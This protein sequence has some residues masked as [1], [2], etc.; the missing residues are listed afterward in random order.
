M[1]GKS[2]SSAPE[3]G[4]RQIK[5]TRQ[6]ENTLQVDNARQVKKNRENR[7]KYTSPVQLSG[8]LESIAE[9]AGRGNTVCDVGCDHAHI[10][11]RLL[12]T[13]AFAR[14]IGMDVLD[15]PLGKAAGNLDLYGMADR[16]DLRLSDGLDAYE[17][18]EADTVVITGM[19]GTLMREILLREPEK[20]RSIPALV[21]GP[22]SDPDKVRDAL[23]GLGFVIE[24]ERLIFED[25]KYYPVLR[26][27]SGGESAACRPKDPGGAGEDPASGDLF[28]AEIPDQIRREAEDLF[29][30]VLLSR[31]DPLLKEFLTR[32]IAVLE[33]IRGSVSEAAESLGQEL[34]AAA[35]PAEAGKDPAPEEVLAKA[36]QDLR[37]EAA[38]PAE[39]GKDPAPETA[40][41]AA[42]R[43]PSGALREKHLQ[44]LREIDHSLVLYRAALAVYREE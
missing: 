29:G 9:L 26:A 41:T 42:D 28:P 11:I 36:G 22:Q 39:A 27:V 4:A 2:G 14:A 37:P 24:D 21:L 32:R 3:G 31:R 43:R 16:V 18:G 5:N 35:A 10:P 15:G 12:Q 34:S 23:R 38:A 44:K 30:P 33:R 6:V 40:V 8:R 25:G 20:T 19:G 17:A 1:T 13:G 7:E